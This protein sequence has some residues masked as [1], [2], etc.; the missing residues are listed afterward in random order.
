LTIDHSIKSLLDFRSWFEKK[1]DDEG[2][3]SHRRWWL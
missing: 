1:V 3:F 2:R